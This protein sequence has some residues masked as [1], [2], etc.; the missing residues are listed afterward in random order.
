MQKI[1][2]LDTSKIINNAEIFLEKEIESKVLPY[3]QKLLNQLSKRLGVDVLFVD[4]QYSF[5]WTVGDKVIQNW[6]REFEEY[7]ELIEFDRV[8]CD[9]DS[10][11]RWTFQEMKSERK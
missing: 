8:T 10:Y 11:R 5:T 4:N 2:K 1:K 3:L 6:M 9:I 7:P